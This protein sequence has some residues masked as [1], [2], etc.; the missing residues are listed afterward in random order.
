MKITARGF[1]IVLCAVL[2]YGASSVQAEVKPVPLSD[3]DC[4]KCHREEVKTVTGQES[5]HKNDIGCL[6]C[7]E[8]HPPPS[9]AVIP[10]CSKC[11]APEESKH[12]SYDT[13]TKCHNPHAPLVIDLTSLAPARPVCI[14]CHEKPGEQ[15]AKYPSKHSDQDCT[16]CHQEHGLGEG[17]SQTCLDCHEPHSDTMTNKDC[18][19][20]HEPHRPLYLRYGKVPPALCA[21]CHEEQ[22]Q[23]LDSNVTRHSKLG[24]TYCHR[25]RHKAILQC[26]ECH[27]KPH[28]KRMHK[29]F[30]D[31]K[32]CHGD[33]HALKK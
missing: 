20:C 21:A 10:K 32:Q 13:C 25:H 18:T 4:I 3:S 2:A 30:S 28:Y 7:H 33:P 14:T 9:K 24:C 15:L 22:K 16:D 26:E 12:F 23:A 31:C 5:A 8:G 17:K 19:L 6:D 29:K 11:H 1:F 27:G